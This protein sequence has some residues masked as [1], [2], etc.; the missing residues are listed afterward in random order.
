MRCRTATLAGLLAGSFLLIVP[1]AHAAATCAGRGATIVGTTHRDVLVGT[2]GDDVVWLDSGNDEFYGAGGDDVV[3]GGEGRDRI[4]GVEGDDTIFGGPGRDSLGGGAGNDRVSGEAGSDVVEGSA[5]DDRVRGGPGDDYFYEGLGDDKVF[6]GSGRDWLSYH[7]SSTGI[8]VDAGAHTVDGAGRDTTSAIETYEGT[9]L[10][11]VMRGGPDDDDLRG[12]AGE[13]RISGRGGDDYV[14]AFDGVVRAGQGN[15]K[16]SAGGAVTVYLGAGTNVATLISGSPRV[17]GGGGRD[18]FRVVRP[19]V[20]ASID[21]GSPGN[22]ISF[23]GLRR[24]VS[25]N[26]GAGKASWRGGGLSF[27]DVHNIVGSRRADQLVGSAATD[28]LFGRGGDD[29]LRGAAGNDLLKGGKGADT[30]KGGPGQ[31]FCSAEHRVGC[32]TNL[33]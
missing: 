8:R 24:S 13:D 30:T 7:G 27:T 21:G 19:A 32:E 3:C 15:D 17:Y 14:E 18:L 23:R 2:Q 5:G 20:Q 28:Y 22:Q 10:G 25:V 31:D 29:T 33:G 1:A 11:D 4:A 26:I 12:M 9:N 16:V 6:G